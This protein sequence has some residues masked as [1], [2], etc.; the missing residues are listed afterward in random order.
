LER[1]RYVA[2][3]VDVELAADTHVHVDVEAD[4][5]A[6]GDR[7]GGDERAAGTMRLDRAEYE[8]ILGVGDD[9]RS[10]VV[11]RDGR[12]GAGAPGA[13]AP[14]HTLTGRQTRG[15]GVDEVLI[16]VL[17][18][19]ER[20]PRVGAVGN[21]SGGLVGEGRGAG[22]GRDDGCRPA[23]V[24]PVQERGRRRGAVDAGRVADLGQQLRVEAAE[25]TVF[26]RPGREERHGDVAV[27]E[28]AH[29]EDAVRVCLRVPDADGD[30]VVLPSAPGEGIAAVVDGALDE[31]ALAIP[32]LDGLARRGEPLHA[33]EGG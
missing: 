20:A 22:R 24:H 2:A 18:I 28:P 8:G 4:R 15:G 32:E 30:A 29:P 10:G 6:A 16:D 12:A 27:P 21:G 23:H 33:V 14:A 3:E 17:L 7:G 5:R 25:A 26:L 13:T 19:T 9:G 31:V 1:L 11:D